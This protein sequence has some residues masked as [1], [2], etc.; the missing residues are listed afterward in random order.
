[1]L[2]NVTVDKLRTLKLTGMA[3]ELSEQLKKPMPNLDFEER[4]GLLIEREWYLRENRR[5]SRR[6]RSADF[7]QQACIEDINYQ[8]SRK[9]NKE[10]TK[11]LI[12]C[13]WIR[14]HLNLLI[15]GP[16]GCGKTW[17]ACAFSHR[18]CLLG[19]TAKY[20]RLPRLWNKLKIAKIDGT[21][22]KLLSEMAKI[23]VIILDDWGIASPDEEQRRDLL[24]ILDDRY[25]KKSTLI[26][27]QLPISHWHEHLNDATIADA[28]LDRLIHNA[29]KMELD[30]PSLRETQSVLLNNLE[31]E[32]QHD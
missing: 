29:I 1:M 32:H 11:D 14:N 24:E 13:Q 5:L 8:H 21:Y 19:L 23:D 31:K 12:R 7:K 6:L 25:Q 22:S 17:L 28:I 20:Y 18:A 2:N 16:T 27:S 10:V 9:L 15:T 30:G 4:L 26:T 3:D